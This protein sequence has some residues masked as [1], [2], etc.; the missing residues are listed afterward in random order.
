MLVSGGA[1]TPRLRRRSRLLAFF[2]KATVHYRFALANRTTVTVAV[3]VVLDQIASS[4]DFDECRAFVLLFHGFL[5]SPP[6][7]NAL[8]CRASGGNARQERLKHETTTG[9]LNHTVRRHRPRSNA[10]KTLRKARS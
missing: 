2:F 7:G 8:L 9:A 3:N 10:C 5:L 4:T 6:S 1:A